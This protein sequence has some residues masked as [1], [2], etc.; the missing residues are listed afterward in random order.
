MSSYTKYCILYWVFALFGSVLVAGCFDLS[1]PDRLDGGA[2]TSKVGDAGNEGRGGGVATS[3]TEPPPKE[4]VKTPSVTGGGG[5]EV[6]SDDGNDG[7]GGASGTTGAD[8]ETVSAGGRGGSSTTGAG[9]R[10]VSA[11]GS[12]GSSTTGAGGSGGAG[13]EGGGGACKAF[14][15][16]GG[17]LDGTWQFDEV[18][19]EGDLASYYRA[20]EDLPSACSDLYQSATFIQEGTITFAGGMVNENITNTEGY[21]FVYTSA[22]ESA[23][24]STTIT[25]DAA[26][27]T[28]RQQA[29]IR[30]NQ[31]K[32]NFSVTC[33]LT[34][35]NCVCATRHQ[36]Q[37][38]TTPTPYTV[39]GDA[40][41]SDAGSSNTGSSDAGSN[42]LYY[43]VSGAT[44]TTRRPWSQSVAIIETLHK[45]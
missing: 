22:C 6:K 19:V 42:P 34:G 14:T 44:L 36:S 40:N 9:G 2:A 41:S 28:A 7:S 15:P 1:L 17:A 35:G 27:C 13:S 3:M 5:V 29:L 33:S 39:S 37:Y 26:Q 25:M 12:G 30:D 23:L 32:L 16:C 11:G 43:C 38:V 10:T 20:T 31:S 8:D 4:Q 45:L 18:C 21:I 24:N